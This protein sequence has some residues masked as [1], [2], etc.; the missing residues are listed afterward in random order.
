MPKFRKVPVMVDAIQ[1]TDEW[2]DGDHPNDLHPADRRITYVPGNRVVVIETIEGN[3]TAGVGDWIIT[4]VEGEVY[5]CK[6]SIFKKTYEP[7]DG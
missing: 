4:G 1:I 7:I 6:D 2:F 5:P 3:M